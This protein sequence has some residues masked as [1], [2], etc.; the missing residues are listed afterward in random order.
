MRLGL[1]FFPMI[2]IGREGVFIMERSKDF[3]SKPN[4]YSIHD[5]KTGN[6]E[7]MVSQHVLWPIHRFSLK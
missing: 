3:I 4:I 7:A 2:K 5:V 6:I 1:L